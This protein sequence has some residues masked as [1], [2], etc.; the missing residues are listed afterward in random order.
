[1]QFAAAARP[2]H[3]GAYTDAEP[4][5]LDETAKALQAIAKAV[6]SKDEAA[7]H[8][9]GK[10][11]SI[12]KT[13]ER[14][15]YLVRGCDALT[16]PVGT[17]TVGKELFHAL[18]ATA[19]QGRPQLRA[20]QFPV[21]ISNR[22]AYGMASMGFGG[23]DL[24]SIPDYHLSAADI[25]GPKEKL[26]RFAATQGRLE[27][28]QEGFAL[29][30]SRYS[31]STAASYRS[32]WNWWG[33]FCRQRGEAYPARSSIQPCGRT[34]C[35]GFPR[36]LLQQRAA[37]PR[38]GQAPPVSYPLDAF[39]I[40]LYASPHAS[41]PLGLGWAQEEVRHQRTTDAGDSR[42]AQVARPA[43]PVRSH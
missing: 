17:A 4:A 27:Y 20:I 23:Q 11:S 28:D 30:L 5:A 18:R 26:L 35:A 10:V 7:A 43:P 39:D 19:T 25:H 6:T 2:R 15:V 40:G 34:A 21:N 16:V 29:L 12:G 1:M 14:I 8:E 33:L 9:K 3:A 38:H 24:K 42:D 13:E 32:Q 31:N 36:A 37:R 41:D 22:V